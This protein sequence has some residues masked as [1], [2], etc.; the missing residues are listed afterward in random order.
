P[1]EEKESY[2]WIKS[3]DKSQSGISKGIRLVHV[4]DREADIYEFFD[5]AIANQQ[6]FLIRVVQNRITTEACKLFD[7]VKNEPPAGKIV[8][9]IPRD[10]RRNLTKREATL[11]IRSIRVHIQ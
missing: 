10:T 6:D 4:G 2:K 1:I 5:H 11:E 7:K 8:V 9:E 3:M